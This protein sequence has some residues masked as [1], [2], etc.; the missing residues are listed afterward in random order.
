MIYWEIILCNFG[1]DHLPSTLNI[2]D[3][4][5]N[6]VSVGD[7]VISNAVPVRVSTNTSMVGWLVPSSWKP[8]DLF[9]SL[10]GHPCCDISHAVININYLR[11]IAIWKKNY[12]TDYDKMDNTRSLYDD[13][14]IFSHFNEIWNIAIYFIILKI[15]EKNYTNIIYTNL[16]LF[17]NKK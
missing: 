13:T 16:T 9:E 2:F 10:S 8:F 17:S 14:R 15:Q 7:T 3:F 11:H 4:I 6:I 12:S 1:R 5:A